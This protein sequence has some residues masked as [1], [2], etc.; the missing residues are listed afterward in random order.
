MSHPQKG[1]ASPAVVWLP[2]A[3]GQIPAQSLQ[4]PA[5]CPAAPPGNFSA[6]PAR[7]HQ[8]HSCKGGECPKSFDEEQSQKVAELEAK[9]AMLRRKAAELDAERQVATKGV[10]KAPP[11]VLT[12]PGLALGTTVSTW[13]NQVRKPEKQ[14]KPQAATKQTSSP[15]LTE[16]PGEVSSRTTVMLRNLPAGFTREK[17]LK[18]LDAEGFKACYD[19]MYLPVDF[20]KWEGFGYAFVNMTSHRE[21]LRIWEHFDGFTAWPCH[22]G[23]DGEAE[24]APC[25]C[26]VCWGDPLQGLDVHIDR[27]RNSPVMHKDVPEHF[28][29]L[30]FS[31]G[32]IVKFPPP[33]KRIRPPRLKHGNPSE[34]SAATAKAR[35]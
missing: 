17:L 15:H 28:K 32:E 25:P 10:M 26:E 16:G 29:P 11:G 4:S 27:Y 20:V 24:S 31:R 2:V 21:A 35:A 23:A 7:D 34:M 9:A 12:A 8:R 22:D 18:L 19:F 33:T 13:L 14:V 6:T 5:M 3:I 1:P 30:I